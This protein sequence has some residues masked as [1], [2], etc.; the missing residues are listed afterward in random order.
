VKA[1]RNSRSHALMARG[2][3]NDA[4]RRIEERMVCGVSGSEARV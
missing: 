4:L 3:S 2:N 1:A